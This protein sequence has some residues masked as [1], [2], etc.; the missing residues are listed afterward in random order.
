MTDSS[1]LSFARDIRP[2]FTE[3][4]VAHMKPAGLDL[5][6]RSSVEQQADSIYAAVSGGSMPPSS[7]GEPRWS[8]QMCERFKEW[9]RQGC[10]P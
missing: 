2:M 8:A 10:P 5:S 3:M 4:D 7:S 1:S 9:Q 6:D